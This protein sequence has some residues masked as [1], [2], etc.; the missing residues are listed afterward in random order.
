MAKLSRR[1]RLRNHADDTAPRTQAGIRN[2]PH[3]PHLTAAIN[4]P[5]A[6]FAE[7]SAHRPGR[8]RIKG[9]SAQS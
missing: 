5:D 7:Q 2:R 1:E 9:Q 3:E 8:L 6:P 4:E